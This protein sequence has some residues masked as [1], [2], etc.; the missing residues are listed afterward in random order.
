[1][2][3]QLIMLILLFSEQKVHITSSQVDTT[4][5]VRAILNC[6]DNMATVPQAQESLSV[7]SPILD[8]AKVVNVDIEDSVEYETEGRTSESSTPRQPDDEAP[9]LATGQWSIFLARSSM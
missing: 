6:I 3:N 8:E 2:C 9:W 1:M 4:L 5:S 7:D